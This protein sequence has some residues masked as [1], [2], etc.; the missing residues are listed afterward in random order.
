[1][2]EKP[3]TG[4]KWISAGYGVFSLLFVGIAIIM[5]SISEW[6]SFEFFLDMLIE[7]KDVVVIVLVGF[8]LS[9]F[10]CVGT[11]NL[12]KLNKPVQYVILSCAVGIATTLMINMLPLWAA[13]VQGENLEGYGGHQ[14]LSSTGL[15]LGYAY[16]AAMLIITFR[17]S[18][19]SLKNGTPKSGAP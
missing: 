11:W 8:L 13:W 5:F 6:R 4:M 7:L 18:N 19:K 16:L 17:A 10:L 3:E 1:M 14:M 9:T 15:S 2:K 12:L